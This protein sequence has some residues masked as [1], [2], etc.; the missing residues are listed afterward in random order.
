MTKAITLK[1]FEI[2]HLEIQTKISV[3]DMF[4]ME[5]GGTRTIRL[6]KQTS[7]DLIPKIRSVTN[8]DAK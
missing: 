4:K 5:D 1:L 7:S 6:E 2:L 3:L 8:M